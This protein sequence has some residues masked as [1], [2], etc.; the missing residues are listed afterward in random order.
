MM[1]L[2]NCE[3]GTPEWKAARSGR[4]TASRVKDILAQGKGGK[5][6]ASRADIRFQIVCEMLSG[7]PQDD[8]FFSKD[9]AWGVDKE[10][11]ARGAYGVEM[12]CIVDQ[13]GMVIHPQDDRCAASPDGMVNWDGE[14]APEGLCEIKCPKTKTHI[15]YIQAGGVPNDY[16]PQMVW[17]MACT[18]AQWNDFVSFDPRLSGKAEG[19]QL[20]ICRLPR[21]EARIKEVEAEVAKFLNE[22]DCLYNTLLKI[23][24]Q[25]A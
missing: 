9:M 3:Q 22:C 2:I 10:P 7:E 14:N 17:Q 8:V 11:L 23:S 18:G 5:E 21:N 4:V 16:E 25:A 20:Y 1:K 13:V 19:L 6:S 24:E 12:G 15:G